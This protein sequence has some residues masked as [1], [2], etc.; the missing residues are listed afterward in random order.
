MNNFA[1]KCKKVAME[2]KEAYEQNFTE[3]E[4]LEEMHEQLGIEH[5]QLKEEYARVVASQKKVAP[6]VDANVAL[7]TV[8]TVIVPVGDLLGATEVQTQTMNIN[9][10]NGVAEIPMDIGNKDLCEWRKYVAGFFVGKRLPFSFVAPG[11]LAEELENQRWIFNSITTDKDFFNFKFNCDENMK[12]IL[13]ANPMYI[14]SKLFGVRQWT[15]EVENKFL[16]LPKQLW[17][18][19]GIIFASCLIGNLY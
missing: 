7:A 9:Y 17:T 16:N 8:P 5:E 14:A 4:E 11:L 18:K 3:L 2:A 13:E 6:L 10:V 15:P 12:L 1:D 19:A